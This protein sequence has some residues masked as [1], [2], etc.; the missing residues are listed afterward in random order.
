MAEEGLHIDVAGAGELITALKAGV[1]PGQIVLH[2]NAKTDHELGLADEAGVGTVV[3]DGWDD[4]SRLE[5]LGGARQSVLLR[6][7]PGVD[8]PTPPRD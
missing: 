5:R 1:P 4:I 3:V 8:A 2:G 7:I 6:V